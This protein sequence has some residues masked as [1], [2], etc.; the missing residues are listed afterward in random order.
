MQLFS[1]DRII[2]RAFSS[3]FR[4]SGD[5]AK[6][7]GGNAVGGGKAYGGGEAQGG[8][9]G[10]GTAGKENNG[11]HKARVGAL[12]RTGLAVRRLP[13]LISPG[14]ASR[15]ARSPLCAIA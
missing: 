8:G 6:V 11:Y 12:A 2:K 9:G 15:G 1:G 3:P 14:R 7:L 4:K 5:G 13:C 10:G